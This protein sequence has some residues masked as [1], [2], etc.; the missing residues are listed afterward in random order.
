MMWPPPT[1]LDELS[2]SKD[3]SALGPPCARQAAWNRAAF[4]R[5][6]R[7][8]VYMPCGVQICLSGVGQGEHV[9]TCP[10]RF[11]VACALRSSH[12]IRRRQEGDKEPFIKVDYKVLQNEEG[13]MFQ[14][15]TFVHEHVLIAWPDDLMGM[16]GTTMQALFS[17][18][19]EEL[20]EESPRMADLSDVMTP[21]T[22]SEA[23]V[24]DWGW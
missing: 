13:N 15:R 16:Y 6:T 14:P 17:I 3:T 10:A 21:P 12:W 23:C 20:V 22:P 1:P 19:C 24:F 18:R 11:E 8:R 2:D 4:D 5:D 7:V 9:L